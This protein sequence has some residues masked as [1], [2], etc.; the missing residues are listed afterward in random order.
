MVSPHSLQGLLVAIALAGP[1]A[2]FTPTCIWDSDTLADELR[3]LPED[4]DLLTGRWFRHSAD[5][6]RHRIETL[7]AHLEAHPSDLAAYDD[8]AV[9][10]ERLSD[11]PSAMA[12][13]ERKASAMAALT[14]EESNAE[15]EKHRYRYHANK[16]T[17]LA[18]SGRF[19]EA[20]VELEKAIAI[21]PAAHFGRE[22][23]QIDLIRYVSACRKDPSLWEQHD[24]MTFANV[25]PSD[26]PFFSITG[27]IGF[28]AK[29]RVD[30]TTR[31]VPWDELHT[32]IVGMLRFGGLEGPEL[33]RALGDLHLAKQNLHL[34]WWAYGVAIERG[35][36]A[37]AQMVLVRD[38]IVRHWR[39]AN[40]H[41]RKKTP[42][43]TAEEFRDARARSARWLAEF[44]RLERAA[45]KSGRAPGEPAVLRE[46]LTAADKA[47]PRN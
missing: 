11:R 47:V 6:Y 22:R 40:E 15:V 19:E 26:Q 35:H 7:P 10:H 27:S 44:H 36:P 13:I 23:F 46:L 12:V 38:G 41:S 43:P 42:I 1:F 37:E 8:L 32:A 30:E 18:H 3:G 4:H 24:F 20:L 34:A 39:E 14:P 31:R 5:Y 45:L 29:F 25:I 33:Y 2:G 28:T 16:G 17:F 9:A 21:E